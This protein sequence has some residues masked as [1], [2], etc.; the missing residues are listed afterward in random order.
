MKNKDNEL[1]KLYELD[2]GD[3]N[4]LSETIE[5][6]LCWIE[7]DMSDM[8]SGDELTY[9]ITCKY[10]TRKEFNELPEWE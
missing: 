4:F 3:T 6:V 7:T 1:I 8:A 2:F 10:I 9:T 5:D